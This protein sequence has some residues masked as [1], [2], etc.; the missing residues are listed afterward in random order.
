MREVG[1]WKEEEAG[2]GRGPSLYLALDGACLLERL[3][4]PL[5]TEL[6]IVQCLH[7]LRND[8]DIV[9]LYWKCY[10]DKVPEQC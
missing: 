9:D 7:Q 10:R 4:L 5:Q 3:Q 6:G 2:E 8:N 1:S